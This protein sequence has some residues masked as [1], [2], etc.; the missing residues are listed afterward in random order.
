MSPD[1]ALDKTIKVFGL[2]AID[3]AERSGVRAQDISRFRRG[4]KDLYLGNF[5]AVVRAMPTEAQ[6]YLVSLVLFVPGVSEVSPLP[7]PTAAEAAGTYKAASKSMFGRYIVNWL[8][9]NELSLDLFKSQADLLCD[10]TSDRIDEIIDGD[11][12]TDDE[13]GYLGMLLPSSTGDPYTLKQLRD[14]RS[15]KLNPYNTNGNSDHSHRGR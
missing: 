13:L 14:I 9:H 7:L 3:L 4:H 2:K 1:E 6:I 5:L 10:M 11:P 12:P 15:G 8:I